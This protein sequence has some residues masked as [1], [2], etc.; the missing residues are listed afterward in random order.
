MQF[1]PQPHN[2]GIEVG[3]PKVHF[4]T[5]AVQHNEILIE[6][7]IQTLENVCPFFRLIIIQ[8]DYYF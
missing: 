1:T 3:N 6:N 8:N 7:D 5:L 2:L 4:N